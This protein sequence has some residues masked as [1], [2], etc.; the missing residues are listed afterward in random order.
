MDF[1]FVCLFHLYLF[2]FES[3]FFLWEIGEFNK[4]A[5]FIHILCKKIHKIS[6]EKSKNNRIQIKEIDN[7][8][9][10]KKWKQINTVQVL[11][12]DHYKDEDR[13]NGLMYSKVVIK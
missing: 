11:K 13:S 4:C 5:H 7:H 3:F 8:R 6:F 9:V 2:P 1:I 12:I 10:G